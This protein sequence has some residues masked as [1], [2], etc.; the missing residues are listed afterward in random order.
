MRILVAEDTR[1][2]GWS[3][4]GDLRRNGHRTVVVGTGHAAV[5]ACRQAD[6]VLLDL[7]LPD[8]DGLEVCRRIRE[9]T[10]V[11]VI[12]L[13]DAATGIERVLALRAG[14]DDCLD[15]PC[16]F[17]ELLA[18][19]EAL[20]RRSGPGAGPLPAVGPMTL[21]PLHIDTG[22]REV[23]VSG[24]PVALTRK[25]FDLLHG[26]ARHAGSVVGRQHLMREVWRLDEGVGV[27]ASRTLDTHVSSLRRKLGHGEWIR[28][29]RGVGFQLAL[30]PTGAAAAARP[31]TSPPR[32]VLV[33]VSD[34]DT[35]T[36]LVSQLRRHG[37]HARACGTGAEALAVHEAFDL[38][39]VN[40]QLPDMDG[41]EVCRR[42]RAVGDM[43]VIAITAPGRT[44]DRIL[45]LRAGA[46][47]CVAHQ[48]DPRELLARAEAVL[49]RA[50]SDRPR[51]RGSALRRGR[52]RLDTTTGG[53][54]F[55]DRAVRLTRKEFELLHRLASE[56]RTVHARARLIAD[57][58]GAGA[59]CP[60]SGPGSGP[61]SRPGSGR[62]LDTHVSAVRSKIGLPGLI[63][64]VRGVGFRFG[65]A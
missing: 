6:L 4:V 19:I 54:R 60:G 15:K 29:A 49:R 9:T 3:P 53:V 2:A 30:E 62:T 58:W 11:P 36:A 40:A 13:T 33:A 28:S 26:L 5:T 44:L 12:A 55:A 34:A 17:Q 23:R 14:A 65:E 47:D 22:A 52:L 48:D 10:R 51:P 61:G 20:A 7:R 16:T 64:T 39:L 24:A 31:R 27:R 37:C 46:D 63:V 8:L 45:F 56:P 38:L 1:A 59:G 21:G 41:V 35:R 18:R 42:V 43:P 32:G 25:E 50:R 57:I